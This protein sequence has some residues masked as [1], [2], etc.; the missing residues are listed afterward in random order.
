MLKIQEITSPKTRRIQRLI[1][2]EIKKNS[3]SNTILQVFKKNKEELEALHSFIKISNEPK[4]NEE[5]L[6]DIEMKLDELLGNEINMFEETESL[7]NKY[8][9]DCLVGR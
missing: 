9:V 1:N 7:I 8:Q 2:K 4:V 3:V 6:D 5:Q